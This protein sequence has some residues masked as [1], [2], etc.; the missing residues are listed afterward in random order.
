MDIHRSMNQQKEKLSEC[1]DKVL[2]RCHK[3]IIASSKQKL[4][5]CFFE[6]PD[7]MFG[8]P[9]YDLNECITYVIDALKSNGFLAVYFFP[10]YVYVS[11]DLAEIERSK[12]QQANNA[13]NP[14]QQPAPTQLPQSHMIDFKYKPSGKLSVKI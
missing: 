8:Y 3:R 5:T 2:E 11:W 4:M 6:V 7:Y 12:Q 13:K 1:F 14:P 10:R 9:L